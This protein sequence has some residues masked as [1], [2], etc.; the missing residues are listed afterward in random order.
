M[1]E[2]ASFT[3]FCLVNVLESARKIFKI[4]LERENFG[5]S[6]L[7]LGSIRVVLHMLFVPY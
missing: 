2:E 1:Q 4:Q 5:I 3:S 6:F 7:I